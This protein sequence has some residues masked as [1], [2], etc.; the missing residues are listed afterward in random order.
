MSAGGDLDIL[1]VGS[2]VAG[3]SAAV[4]A[5]A[6]EPGLRVG[7]ITKSGLSASATAWAQGGVAAVMHP[8]EADRPEDGDSVELHAADTLR[9]GGGLCDRAAV[10]VLVREGPGRVRELAA[11]GASFDRTAAGRWELA[12]EGGHTVARVIHAGGVA[13]GAEVE[14]TLVDAARASAARVEEHC[15]ALDLIVEGGRCRGVTALTAGGHRTALRAEH[16]LLATG[17]AGQLYPVT[18]N[19]A[20]ATGAGVAMALRAGVAVADVEFVQFHPTALYLPAGPGPRPLLSE[21][22]RGEGAL[23]RDATGR[24]F[25][26]EMQPRDV[27]AAAVAA[28]I[29]E[30]GLGHVWLD[31][32]TLEGFDRR[33]P[34]LAAAVRA[35]GLDPARDWLPVAPAAHYLCGGVMTDL[36]GATTLPGLWA[37]GEVACSGVH[38]ANRLASNSLLEGLVFSARAVEAILRKKDRPAPTGALLP[39][40]DPRAGADIGAER[41]VNGPPVPTGDTDPAKVREAVQRVMVEGAGVVRDAESLRMA[42]REI[43]LLAAE[44]PSEGEASDLVTLARAVIAG[45]T[46]RRETRGG[47]RRRDFPDTDPRL[48]RRFVQW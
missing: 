30:S 47:H 24:R 41:L 18:T 3:L 32:S 6:A 15:S 36:D 37:A 34:S 25:V 22:L 16:T 13:T 4:R 27:V 26:D 1:I 9:A 38:G 19:P 23:L 21:A 8:E 14:R 10:D 11:L 2:G 28:A 33:F 29:G 40:L 12:R 45:A 48:S 42:R 5:A 31:V 7:V 43:E 35:A 44:G 17:G 20:E 39:V 46:A